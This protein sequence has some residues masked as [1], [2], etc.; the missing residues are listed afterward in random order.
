MVPAQGQDTSEGD[1]GMIPSAPCYL[2]PAEAQHR[3]EGV[4]EQPIEVSVLNLP[5][6]LKIAGKDGLRHA[7]RLL[8]RP[9]WRLA[10][11]PCA[12]PMPSPR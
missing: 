5:R 1:D 6:R 2:E 7:V 8:P 9:V 11:M 4:D 10:A 3:N 12:T